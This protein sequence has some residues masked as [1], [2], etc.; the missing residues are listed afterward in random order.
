MGGYVYMGES[1][2]YK[3]YMSVKTVLSAIIQ[4]VDVNMNA[5]VAV[6]VDVC[7]CLNYKKCVKKSRMI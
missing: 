7:I 4:F 3:Y 5:C 6:D 2:V 1:D